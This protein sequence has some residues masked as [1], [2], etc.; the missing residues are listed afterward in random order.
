MDS[1]DGRAATDR[2]VSE[3]RLREALRTGPFS[4]ALHTALS[5]RG[6]ALHRA[7]QRLAERGIRVGV[8]TLSYWQRGIRRPDRL[9]SLRAVTA[10]EDVLDLPEDALSRLLEPRDV[11]GHPVGRRYST[12]IGSE[13]GHL[14]AA[15]EAPQDGGLHTVMQYESVVI[16]GGRRLALRE[17]QQVVRTHRDG[18]DRYVAIH[19]GEHGCA[20]EQVR[21]TGLGNCRV[22]RV[23]RS[24]EAGL[25]VAELLFDTRLRTGETTVLRYRFE[26]GTGETSREYSRGF[27]YAGIPYALQVA[28]DGAALPVRCRSFTRASTSVPATPLAD[29][30]LNAHGTVHVFDP[31]A[32]PGHLGV[33]WDWE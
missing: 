7:R 6:L 12:L 5:T 3:A 21:V 25:V 32:G 31:E 10:L 4:L 17:T 2:A 29:L 15:L 8:T 18:I 9:E 26:D 27:V 30:T 16:D 14:L 23:R 24:E 13:V 11:A 28:F 22:G 19:V 33:C 20:T 1:S